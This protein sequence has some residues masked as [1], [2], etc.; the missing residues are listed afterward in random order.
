MDLRMLAYY[1]GRER[2]VPELAA[3]AESSGL[4]VVSTHSAGALVVMRLAC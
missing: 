4:R 2:G 1:G 3:L